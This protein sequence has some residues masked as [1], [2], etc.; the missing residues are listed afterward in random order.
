MCDMTAL[1]GLHGDLRMEVIRSILS[2]AICRLIIG[3]VKDVATC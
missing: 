2:S 1:T 3:E